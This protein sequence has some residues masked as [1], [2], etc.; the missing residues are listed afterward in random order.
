MIIFLITEHEEIREYAN[1]PVME[2]QVSRK[3]LGE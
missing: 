1:I 2:R 3:R